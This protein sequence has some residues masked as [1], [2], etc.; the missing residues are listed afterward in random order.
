M[1][2]IIF[3]CPKCKKIRFFTKI[4]EDFLGNYICTK[5]DTVLD[6][7]IKKG[8]EKGPVK[9]DPT[10]LNVMTKYGKIGEFKTYSTEPVPE[11]MKYV[12]M[13]WVERVNN[14]TQYYCDK[15]SGFIRE[16]GGFGVSKGMTHYIHFIKYYSEDVGKE[17]AKED[18]FEHAR[19]KLKE[20][21]ITRRVDR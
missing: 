10:A 2:R 16:T 21:N 20:F 17:W 5:C 8:L 18:F 14:N 6:D 3:K 13:I 9:S 4:H 11:G 15:N 1:F 12:F 19:M 7:Q